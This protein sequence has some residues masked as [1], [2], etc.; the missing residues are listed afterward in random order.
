MSDQMKTCTRCGMS[1]PYS[2]FYKSGSKKGHGLRGDCKDCRNK[3]PIIRC[4]LCGKEAKT[5]KGEC[6]E[7]RRSKP[8]KC[9]ACNRILPADQFSK[10]SDGH[11]CY[12]IPRAEC[13]ECCTALTREYRRNLDPESRK[14]YKS[15]KK[16]SYQKNYGNANSWRARIRKL[17][18]DDPNDEILERAMSTTRCDCCS[19][20]LDGRKNKT[21]D[22]DH[23]T[24]KFRGILCA[25]CNLG[26]GHFYDDPSR[27]AE[28]ILYLTT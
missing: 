19:D 11:G 14:R 23:K 17:G 27:L 8:K 22:H 25:R 16:R 12:G 21:I 24:G 6:N 20:S 4:S 15:I 1:K 3:P 7:C 13:K 10:R 18:L 9:S 5:W 26:I 28:A 2:S